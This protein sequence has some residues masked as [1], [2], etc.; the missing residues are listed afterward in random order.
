[1]DF[2]YHEQYKTSSNQ[3]DVSQLDLDVVTAKL[4]LRRGGPAGV[5][6]YCLYTV[7]VS[8]ISDALCIRDSSNSLLV[9]VKTVGS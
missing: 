6:T 4:E 5:Y 8:R 2:S 7:V 3:P 1:M 9:S